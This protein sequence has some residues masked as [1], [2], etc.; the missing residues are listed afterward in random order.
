MPD[1]GY[2]ANLPILLLLSS[3]GVC[4]AAERICVAAHICSV[5]TQPPYFQLTLLTAPLYWV[6]RVA[7]LIVFMEL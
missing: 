2:S 6:P 5:A 1:K 3:S 4:V 7:E